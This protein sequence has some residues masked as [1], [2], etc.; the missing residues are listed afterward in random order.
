MAEPSVL[1]A[2]QALPGGDR[3]DVRRLGFLAGGYLLTRMVPRRL[4]ARVVDR[5]VRSSLVVRES[6]V[7]EIARSIKKVLGSALPEADFHELAREYC[8]MVRDIQ[9][10]R[11]EVSIPE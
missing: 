8:R 5:L 1:S 7:G 11:T 2:L 6:W 4:D 9:E 10:S 3:R